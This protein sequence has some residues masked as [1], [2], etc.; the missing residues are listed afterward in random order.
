MYDLERVEELYNIL[1]PSAY[2]HVD[3]ATLRRAWHHVMS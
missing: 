3:I 2:N 1:Y